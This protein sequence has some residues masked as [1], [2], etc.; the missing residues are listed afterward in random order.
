MLGVSPNDP[1]KAEVLL[2]SSAKEYV[3]TQMETLEKVG[4]N[5]IAMEPE[6][7]ALGRALGANTNDAATLI[8]DFGTRS[9]DVVVM[10][11]GK[12]RLVRSIPGGFDVIVQTVTTAMGVE[13][14]KSR[15]FILRFGLAQDKV[16]GQVFKVLDK[17]L[18]NYAAELAKSVRFFQT[19]YT[20]VKVGTIILSGFAA[21]IPLMAE[22]IEA[23]TNITTEVGNPWQFVKMTSD[24]QQALASVASEFSVALGLAERSND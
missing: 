14:A 5:V 4:F 18:S 24:Q 11:R 16:E 15:E 17:P 8:V 1:G 9:T 6:P 20:N 2:S 7:L 10:Y 19:N 21:Q 3:E 23:K 13:A 22:Y 12:P